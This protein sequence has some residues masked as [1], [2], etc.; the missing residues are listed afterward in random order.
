MRCE[1]D[2]EI[3]KT[4]LLLPCAAAIR[5]APRSGGGDATLITSSIA[6]PWPHDRLTFTFQY[7]AHDE[8]QTND[9]QQIPF[10]R[11]MGLKYSPS[12][13]EATLAFSFKTVNKSFSD[14]TFVAYFVCLA[15]IICVSS[16][17][18]PSQFHPFFFSLPITFVYLHNY[19]TRC[20]HT[21][22][23]ILWADRVL[24]AFIIF[25]IQQIG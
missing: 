3:C 25:Q 5:F 11:K 4:I 6:H 18:N 13:S 22:L 21:L 17:G 8:S 14:T 20:H 23:Q 24:L 9:H 2:G 16:S 7:N 1:E 15:S 12:G 19:S 10:K